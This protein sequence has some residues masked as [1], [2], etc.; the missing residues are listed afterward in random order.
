V[1]EAAPPTSPS[2]SPVLALVLAGLQLF[3]ALILSVLFLLNVCPDLGPFRCA[4]LL[5]P[6]IGQL[7]PL[8]L[9]ELAVAG[10]GL[11][12]VALLWARKREDARAVLG[13]VP[14]LGAGLALAA[15]VLALSATG[16]LC[17]LCSGLAL[18][19]CATAAATWRWLRATQGGAARSVGFG[20]LAALVIGAPLAL[21]RGRWLAEDT[22]ARLELV[23]PFESTQGA[24]IL[25]LSRAGCAHCETLWLDIIADERVLKALGDL[26]LERVYVENAL[27][28]QHAQGTRVP[29]VVLVTPAGKASA[30]RLV[31]TSGGV[32]GFLE[33][34]ERARSK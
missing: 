16:S 13:F 25:V 33:W 14:G 19:T 12:L 7:G 28:K 26:H 11:T 4:P 2:A 22:Q 9:S 10:S 23:A 30:E 21:A 6:R 29:Q 32:E 27:F 31:G 34:L 8:H 1:S 3:A 18:L 17:P 20:V 24:R 15:Q 5:R